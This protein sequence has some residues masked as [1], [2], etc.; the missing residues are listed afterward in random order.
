MQKV[1]K[2]NRISRPGFSLIEI[3]ISLLVI[4]GALTTMFSGFETSGQLD[5]H[6]AFESEA[7]FMAERELELIKSDL[8]AGRLPAKAAGQ[9]GRFRSKPGWKIATTVAAPDADNAVRL[10]VTARK[11][12]RVFQLESFVFVPPQEQKHD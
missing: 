4:S 7:A 8:L 11:G 5:M 3:L 2:L 9:P 12:E 6:A 1:F 10:Q